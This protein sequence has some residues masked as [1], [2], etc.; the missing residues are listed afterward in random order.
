MCPPVLLPDPS[1][2][3][4]GLS[5]QAKHKASLPHTF[6]ITELT[7]VIKEYDGAGTSMPEEVLLRE[8]RSFRNKGP[9]SR[10]TRKPSAQ[11][12]PKAKAEYQ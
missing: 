10:V 5:L 4:L 2:G 6:L 1:L 3:S 9:Q 11:E 7:V 8:Q 12:L